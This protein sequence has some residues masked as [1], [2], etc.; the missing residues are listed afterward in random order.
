MAREPTG[1]IGSGPEEFEKVTD[2]DEVGEV[3]WRSD[4]TDEEGR[5]EVWID[6]EKWMIEPEDMQ[7]FFDWLDA[8]YP[9]VDGEWLDYSPE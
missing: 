9:D 2:W 5:V 8:E 3:F 6:D 1:D 7:D 4:R